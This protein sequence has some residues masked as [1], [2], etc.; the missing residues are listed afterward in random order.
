MVIKESTGVDLS[1]KGKTGENEP[2]KINEDEEFRR[3]V[4]ES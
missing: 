4:M 1:G 3:M 2:N